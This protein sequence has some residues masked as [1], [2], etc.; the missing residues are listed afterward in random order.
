MLIVFSPSF[1]I[2]TLLLLVDKKN[3]EFSNTNRYAGKTNVLY[4]LGGPQKLAMLLV[5]PPCS[6]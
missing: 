6:L 1:V 2:L 3:Q 4:K 5:R